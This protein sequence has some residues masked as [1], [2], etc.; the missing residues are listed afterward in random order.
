MFDI[1]A[2]DFTLLVRRHAIQRNDTWPYDIQPNDI[3][4]KALFETL[5]INNNRKCSYAECRILFTVM[6][7]VAGP[8]F[9]CGRLA[10]YLKT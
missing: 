2:L 6:L 9:N 1:L 5:T 4:M 7:S 3:Q 8:T 10:P